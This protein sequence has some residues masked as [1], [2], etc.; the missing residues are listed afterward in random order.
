MTPKNDD[1]LFHVRFKET[2]LVSHF[3][4]IPVKRETNGPFQT[5]LTYEETVEKNE[6]KPYKNSRSRFTGNR[7]RFT[8]FHISFQHS[9][10]QTH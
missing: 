8:L 6:T 1:F 10:P 4:P 2:A 5:P 7:A 9:T 3:T